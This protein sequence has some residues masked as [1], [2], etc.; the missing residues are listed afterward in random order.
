M[1]AIADSTSF[2]PSRSRRSVARRLRLSGFLAWWRRE[3][4]A[5]MPERIGMAFER[6][7]A[8]P[9]LAFDGNTA[10]LWRPAQ[11]NGRLAMREAARISLDGDAQAVSAA[12]RSAVA[13]PAVANGAPPGVGVS[14]SPPA[15]LRKKQTLPMARRRAD[16]SHEQH[17]QRHRPELT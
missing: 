9:V 4:A 10:T 17:G 8:R 12:G 14:L 1:A 2:K 16:D 11:V 13:P 7:R 3:L 15:T 6:R 5:A